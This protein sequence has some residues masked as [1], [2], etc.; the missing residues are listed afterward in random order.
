MDKRIGKSKSTNGRLTSGMRGQVV[1]TQLD[2]TRL[3]GGKEREKKEE[4]N[5]RILERESLPS[6]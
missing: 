6:L 5:K 3:D 2:P 1:L 4:E